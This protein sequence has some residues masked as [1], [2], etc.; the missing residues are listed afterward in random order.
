MRSEFS[1][2]AF[3]MPVDRM[4]EIASRCAMDTAVR[5]S[6]SRPSTVSSRAVMPHAATRCKAERFAQGL[7]G[8]SSKPGWTCVVGYDGDQAVGYAYRAPLPVD[9]RW[10][11]GLRAEISA[12]VIEETGS[13]TYALS[14]LM[15]R[16]PWRKTGISR[17]LH[18]ALLGPR[19][20]ERATLLVDQ[21]HPKV[22]ALYESWGWHTL[23]D[24]QPR[25]DG[26]PLFHAMLLP[27]QGR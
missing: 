22:W 5:P 15:V 25:L 16:R 18:D 17:Q 10:W 12:D 24:L 23:G 11:G 21:E 3:Q 26:A 8:W 27:L 20:E 1:V 19:P 7:D 9:A 14:E 4:G 13:R 6:A 2:D